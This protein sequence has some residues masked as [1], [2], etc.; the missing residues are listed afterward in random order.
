M[1]SIRIPPHNLHYLYSILSH[2]FTY[3]ASLSPSLSLKT[4]PPK[5]HWS[6]PDHLFLVVIFLSSSISFAFPVFFPPFLH[7]FVTSRFGLSKAKSSLVLLVSAV[8]PPPFGTRCVLASSYKPASECQVGIWV[9][10]IGVGEGK[11]AFWGGGQQG[12]TRSSSIIAFTPLHLPII[13]FFSHSPIFLFPL[14][15]SS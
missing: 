10:D 1:L 11:G 12:P 14:C 9:V 13:T 6:Y 2:H 3:P 4:W 5:S 8:L 7:C 15:V